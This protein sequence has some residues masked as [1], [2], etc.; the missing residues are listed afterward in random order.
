[1]NVIQNQDAIVRTSIFHLLRSWFWS[2]LDLVR[3]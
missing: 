3:L 1:L 2:S